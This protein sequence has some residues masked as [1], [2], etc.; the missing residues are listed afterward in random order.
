MQWFFLIAAIFGTVLPVSYL[1]PFL[2]TN[3]LD[4]PL[5]F[6]QL[7]QNN[8]SGFFAMDVSCRR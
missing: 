7:F 2:V 1:I 4:L 3:G 5:F 6:R 8:I